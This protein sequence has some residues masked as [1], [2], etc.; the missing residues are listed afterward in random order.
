MTIPFR[1]YQIYEWHVRRRDFSPGE[2]PVPVFESTASLPENLK[3]PLVYG[4]IK[5]KD[6]WGKEHTHGFVLR[7]HLP[8]GAVAGDIP[9]MPP[10]F[11]IRI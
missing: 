3:R 8:E 10:T 1:L 4:A 9:E 11:F 6:I 2:G 5:F 7:I